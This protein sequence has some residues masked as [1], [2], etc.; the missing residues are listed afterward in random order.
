MIDL[1]N[2]NVLMVVRTMG[3]GGTENVVLQLCNILKPY[4]NKI[5][6]CSSGGCNVSKLSEVGIKHYLVP[7]ITE[8][9]LKSFI[10]IYRSLNTIIDNEK[11]TIVHT[12]HRMAAFY[13][14][15]LYRKKNIKFLSTAH[16]TFYDKKLF[17]KF[18]YK[19]SK[20]IACGEMV[21]KNLVDFY[22]LP[23][24]QIK[25]IHNAVEPFDG[26]IEID[27]LLDELKKKNKILVGNVGRLS[28]QKGMEY[29]IQ[30]LPEVLQS[31][32]NVMYIIIGDGEDRKK[33]HNL[34]NELCLNDNVI[35]LGYRNDIRNV[36]SQLDFIVL[37]SLWEG[38]P[39]T[40]IEAFSVK[41]TV[42]GTAVDGTVEII[43]DNENGFLIEPKNPAM[44]AKK[45]VDLCKDEKLKCNL[46]ENAYSTFINE[47]SIDEF[48]NKILKFYNSLNNYIK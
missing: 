43:K 7:D 33:L 25:V 42:I 48:E 18:S 13:T 2:Q 4:V 23:S 1:E 16:N 9:N 27:P 22:G 24:Q 29:F 46:E 32:P 36:M 26:N 44:I 39:L 20:I 41:K 21:K 19:H 31:C 12:H 40:P 37:S 28:E 47:F 14:E 6:V 34:V 30:S 8:K 10:T 5:V 3:L 15:L 45:V 35:F 17:T 11:I 38:L